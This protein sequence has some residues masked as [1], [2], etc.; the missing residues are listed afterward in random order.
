MREATTETVNALLVC[1]QSSVC[2]LLSPEP[3]LWCLLMLYCNWLSPIICPWL[4]TAWILSLWYLHGSF[5]NTS[6][7]I[8]AFNRHLFS[9]LYYLRLLSSYWE[10]HIVILV[11]QSC[12]FCGYSLNYRYFVFNPFAFTKLLR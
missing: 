2:F 11:V 10:T 6:Y 12:K 4:S 9:F 5:N 3:V 7:T 1:S 8:T